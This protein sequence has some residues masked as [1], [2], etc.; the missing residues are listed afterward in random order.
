[1]ATRRTYTWIGT[2]GTDPAYPYT[3]S[4]M[5]T[6]TIPAGVNI[7]MLDSHVEWRSFSSQYVQPR[8]GD[9]GAPIY[10]Y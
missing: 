6:P 5:D 1:M 2:I 8:A 10:Y 9:G 3:T 4:H 7:G